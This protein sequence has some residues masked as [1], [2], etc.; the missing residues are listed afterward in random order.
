MAGQ[1][2]QGRQNLSDSS[3]TIPSDSENYDAN[4][5]LSSSPPSSSSSP[6][7]L[8]SPPTIWSLVRG[9]AINL[10]LPFINGLMLGFGELFAHE[11]AF[12]FG[13]SGTKFSSI[14]QKNTTLP[15]SPSRTQHVDR[16]QSTRWRN[17]NII[18]P[19]VL[20]TASSIR[21][22]STSST[23]TGISDAAAASNPE[24]FVS[25][26]EAPFPD[27]S[28][29]PSLEELT[30][31]GL[32]ELVNLPERIGYLKDIGLD[33]GW[34]PTST[35]QWLLEHIHVYSALP[36][37]LSI[38]ATTFLVR[39]IITP[40]Y[41]KQADNVARTTALLPITK[42]LRDRMMQ[43]MRDGNQQEA[44]ILRQQVSQI[45]KDNNIQP[46]RGFI[47]PVLSGMMGYGA[48]RL[49]RAMATTVPSM[50][51]AGFLW[52]T[53]L[54]LPDPLW[55]LPL[56]AASMMHLTFRLGGESGSSSLSPVQQ[57]IFLYALPAV[58]FVVSVYL[59]AALQ[60]SFVCNGL[61]ALV[62]AFLFRQPS[63]RSALG[64]A[65]LYRPPPAGAANKFN[66]I[67]TKLNMRRPVYEAPTPETA[68]PAKGVVE[69]TKSTFSGMVK[70]ATENV[71]AYT[72]G[73]LAKTEKK[74]KAERMRKQAE[75]YEK[76]RM[77]EI[78]E[79]R[80]YRRHGGR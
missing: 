42:P 30:D 67:E 55:I 47:G 52:F 45:N 9:A 62:Q 51:D 46:F 68:A 39:V 72:G 26:P 6:L 56:G 33:Y 44:T 3:M 15:F 58:I 4:H 7:I 74:K 8:Y 22:K 40:L 2:P 43:A 37:G 80:G 11:V 69:K 25:T 5:E 57:R 18:A 54:T 61:L 34:G 16:L 70:S 1:S 13:W 53:D 79:A 24:A 27:A 36:W 35:F 50:T 10:L 59:P 20:A 48:F 23:P 60:L 73:D 21:F 28:S 12:R 19:A 31:R 64:I 63:V 76:K 71:V 29:L 49:L 77:A 78:D 65:P 14:S 32:N 66:A 38:I 17:S 41:V 75:A